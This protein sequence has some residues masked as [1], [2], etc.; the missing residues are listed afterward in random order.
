MTIINLND[1]S[2]YNQIT[3]DIYKIFKVEN[4]LEYSHENSLH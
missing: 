4:V 2:Q 3:I 1:N